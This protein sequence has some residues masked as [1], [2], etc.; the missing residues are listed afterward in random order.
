MHLPSADALAALNPTSAGN[1]SQM[2]IAA[3][4]LTSGCKQGVCL[5]HTLFSSL[6]V[7]PEK[8][9]AEKTAARAAETDKGLL[10]GVFPVLQNLLL[11]PYY[12]PGARITKEE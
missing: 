7:L 8:I 5:P 10:C 11:R 1:A 9:P 12:V 4:S 6:S 2:S 3:V